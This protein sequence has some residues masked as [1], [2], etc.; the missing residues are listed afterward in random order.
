MKFWSFKNNAVATSGLARPRCNFGKKTSR[1][2]LVVNGL[3]KSPAL[4]SGCNLTLNMVAL[5]G[6]AIES[7]GLSLLKTNLETVM[8]L[9]PGLEGVSINQNNCTL[10]KSLG[11]NK[12]VIGGIVC[13]IEDTDLACAHL[14]SPGEVS[15][16]KTECAPLHVS[17][18]AANRVDGFLPNLGHSRWPA[19]FE[20]A[21]LAVLLTTT[22]GLAALVPSF[23]CDTHCPVSLPS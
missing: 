13:Y 9:I 16:V 7:R 11:T 3:L 20:L 10:H 5:F 2:H 14:S 8:C 1:S 23:A 22:T 21:L 4:L 18:T 15:R 17:S 12:L 19:H 6:V